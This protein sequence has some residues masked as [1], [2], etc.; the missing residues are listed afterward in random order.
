M[1]VMARGRIGLSRVIATGENLRDSPP[2]AFLARVIGGSIF[3]DEFCIKFNRQ[4]IRFTCPRL[5]YLFPEEISR[6]LRLPFGN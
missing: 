3:L 5:F 4:V 1:L 6:L 2:R